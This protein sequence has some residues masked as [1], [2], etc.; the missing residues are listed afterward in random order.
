MPQKPENEA[1]GGGKA[2][3]Q[4]EYEFLWR[5]KWLTSNAQSV[6]D[7][8][9]CLRAAIKD[10]QNYQKCPQITPDFQSAEDDYIWFRTGDADIAKKFDFYE[11]EDI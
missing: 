10:L 7:M 2:K 3:G 1:N 5:N 4:A 8:I 11:V 6:D 9:A